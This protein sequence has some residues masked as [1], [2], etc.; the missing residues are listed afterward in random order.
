M[1]AGCLIATVVDTRALWETVVASLVAGVGVTL[2]FSIALFG[3][4]RFAE[5]RR[6]GRT[7][8]A[9]VFAGLALFAAA[10]FL[11]AIVFGIIVMTSK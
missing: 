2:V 10:A 5:H 9:A 4:V 7:G 3:S 6:E 8:T 11:A 1:S